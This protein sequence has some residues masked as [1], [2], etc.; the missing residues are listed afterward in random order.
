MQT[1]VRPE[2]GGHYNQAFFQSDEADQ[3]EKEGLA[4]TVLADHEA[5]RG[6]AV[7]DALHV[8][9]HLVHFA[10]SS[11]LDVLQAELWNDAG[12]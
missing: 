11:H 7:P 3:V 1:P 6:A 2:V 12:P 5:K 9:D 8:L 10:D 4:R